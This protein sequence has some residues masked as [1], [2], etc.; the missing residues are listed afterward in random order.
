[1]IS[2]DLQAFES[3]ARAFLDEASMRRS[4][5]TSDNVGDQGVEIELLKDRDPEQDAASIAAAKTWLRRRWEAGFGWIDGPVEHGGR[6]LPAA[7]A[8]LYRGLE[9]QY[10]VPDL[11]DFFIG[12]EI[13]LPSI[14]AHASDELR[15]AYL[16]AIRSGEINVCQLFS[17]PGAGSDLASVKT[18][19]IRDGDGWRIS[20]QKVWTSGAQFAQ[21]GELLA[22]TDPDKPKHRGITAFLVDMAADGVTV[23][24]LR[25]MTGGAHFNEV[26]LDDVF[27]HDDH[28]IG[29]IDGGWAV[30]TTTLMSERE[31]LGRGEALAPYLELVGK[32][33]RA[34]RR[35][36][37]GDDADLRQRLARAW[38]HA[39]L[40]SLPPGSD[41]AGPELSLSKLGAVALMRDISRLAFD[42]FGSSLTAGGGDPAAYQWSKYVTG[43]PGCSIAGGTDEVLRSIVAER[44]L[45]LPREADPTVKLAFREVRQG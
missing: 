28:R 7:Y 37:R 2:P 9:S 36:G 31:A 10:E 39:W 13:I 30:A 22:R 8:H 45:G 27:V 14:T 5:M 12:M 20:G 18:R 33:C 16:P 32:L 15:N 24:P 3:E 17:E 4:G 43:V 40:L 42:V 29:E 41:V 1:M 26:F 25:Q 11:A 19:A 6:G 38:S 35:T 34:V 23:R 44:V 21:R